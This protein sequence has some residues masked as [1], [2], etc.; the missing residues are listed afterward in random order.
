MQEYKIGCA[1][2][3]VHGTPDPERVKEASTR[4]L[5]QVMQSKKKAAKEGQTEVRFE[6]NGGK[7]G[8]TEKPG[9]AGR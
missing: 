7:D 8:F 6:K 9:S 3:R 2:G 1:V 5:K 4:F